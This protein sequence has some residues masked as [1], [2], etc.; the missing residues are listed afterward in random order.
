MQTINLDAIIP[1][2][3]NPRKHFDDPTMAD[4]SESIKKHGVLQPVL[5]RPLTK[6]TFELVAGERRFRAAMAAGLKEIPATVREL[7]DLEVLEIQVVENLQRS[8][9]HPLEEAEGYRRLLKFKYT[10]AKIAERVGRS[11]P[12]VYDR[13]KLLDLIE[14][15]RK[16]FLEEMI[17]AGH[18]IILAR[19]KPEDQKRAIGDKNEYGGLWQQ[20]DATF[21]QEDADQESRKP[22]SVKELEKWIDEHVKFDAQKADAM[23]FPDL[24]ESVKQAQEKKEKIVS[25]TH[26][27]YIQE[28]ARDGSKVFGPRSWARADGKEGSKTCLHSVTGVV[29]VGFGRGT[30]FKV[31]TEKEKCKEHWREWQKERAERA[32]ARAADDGSAL[33]RQKK[34]DE[35]RK[36]EEAQQVAE[37]DRWR[38]AI[39]SILDALAA[40]VQK[41]PTRAEGFLAGLVIEACRPDWNAVKNPGEYVPVGKS[42]EDAIRHAAFLILSTEAK[43]EYHAPREF[44][45]RAKALGIDIKKILNERNVPN[46][47]V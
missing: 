39:P 34:E 19:L 7:S 33:E 29:V 25:I 8:D 11:V 24:V 5:V 26:E 32:K 40:A 37:R 36:A 12:Y 22:R 21:W 17:T 45:K 6:T 9:L 38:K 27:N 42:A 31:C 1:S 15:A 35:R 46:G 4:L 41:A 23:L 16:L 28:D 44:P 20:E 2:K 3:T 10:A 47:S 18:A 13:I 14:P 43:N 30:A